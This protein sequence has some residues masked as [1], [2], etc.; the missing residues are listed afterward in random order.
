MNGQGVK[1]GWKTVK[2]KLAPRTEA[3]PRGRVSR[4]QRYEI[5]AVM[6]YRLQGE[7][8]W[9]KGFM[10]NMSISGVLLQAPHSIAPDTSI[11]LRFSL[12]VN[13]SGENAAEVLCRG[14]VVRSSNCDGAGPASMVAAK[15]KHSRF[16]RQ[17][18]R[19]G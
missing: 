13:L 7:K 4:A 1:P 3:V 18:D 8:E 14:L 12:P 5:H 6:Q 16:L 19:K 17:K 11:E 10:K 2:G 15:I 9:R